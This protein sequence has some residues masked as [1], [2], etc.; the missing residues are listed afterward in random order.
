MFAIPRTEY[1]EIQKCGY[2]GS[3]YAGGVASARVDC[4]DKRVGAGR[5]AP[6]RG[7]G[8]ATVGAFE[9][10]PAATAV[11][12]QHGA[13]RVAD[14]A[15]DEGVAGGAVAQDRPQEPEPVPAEVSAGSYRCAHRVPF[16]A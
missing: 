6:L 14:E 15:Q 10:G 7:L 2:A 11:E 16:R 12:A 13:C 1:G 4:P 5:P 8:A 9:R 3:G